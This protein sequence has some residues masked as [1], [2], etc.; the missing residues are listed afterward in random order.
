MRAEAAVKTRHVTKSFSGFMAVNDVNFEVPEGQLRAVIGPNGAGKTTFFR[1]LSGELPVSSGQLWFEGQE[2]THRPAFQ[3]AR[4]G[5]GRSYQITNGFP[6]LTVFENM[7]IAAQPPSLDFKFWT[8]YREVGA[9]S[10]TTKRILDV[11]ELG[12]KQNIVAGE[13]SYGDRRRLELA[14]AL[15]KDPRVLLLDEPTAGMTPK[16]TE[17]AIELI[18]RISRGRTVILVEHKMKLVMSLCDQISVFHQGRILAEGSPE[19]I[20]SNREVQSIYFGSKLC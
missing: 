7:Q 20:R 17:S 15:G 12:S 14:M 2:V 16:E 6:N 8:S 3:L 1:L 10:D 11:V 4:L 19:E 5:V 18:R 13:L 9:L